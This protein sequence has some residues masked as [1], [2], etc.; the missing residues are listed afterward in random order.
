M[1]FKRNLSAEEIVAQAHYFAKHLPVESLVFMGMGE[2]FFNLKNVIEAAKTLNHE[3]DLNIPNRK[4]TFSTIGFPK[5]ILKFTKESKKYHLAWSLVAPTDKTRQQL[6]L[7]KGLPTI[8][9]TLVALNKYQQLTKQRVIIE[10]VLLKGIND[11][12]DDLKRLA[13]ISR[14]VDSHIN[15]IEYNPHPTLGYTTGNVNKAWK[16]LKGLGCRVTTRKSM[17]KNILA[18]CGQLVSK[19]LSPRFYPCISSHTFRN[20]PKPR[21]DG[22]KLCSKR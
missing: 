7:Y 14:K 17:G 9:E 18:G 10:Y 1:G 20:F 15:L 11:G 4:M 16:Y 6:I 21:I 22:F 12:E 5:Q 8:K 13:A 2:P 3:T 19:G